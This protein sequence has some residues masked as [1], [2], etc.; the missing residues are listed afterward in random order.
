MRE[1]FERTRFLE[2]QDYPRSWQDCLKQALSELN[3][4]SRDAVNCFDIT[5]DEFYENCLKCYPSFKAKR[6]I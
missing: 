1:I 2:I 3:D 5:Y 6:Y 4:A